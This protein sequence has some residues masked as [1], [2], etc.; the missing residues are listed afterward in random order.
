[1]ENIQHKIYD[2]NDDSDTEDFA[3]DANEDLIF[4]RN[5]IYYDSDQEDNPTNEDEEENIGQ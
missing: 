4:T 5:H 2:I 1:M 3:T